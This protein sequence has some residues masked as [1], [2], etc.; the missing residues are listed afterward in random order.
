MWG[1][2][3]GGFEV[4][5]GSRGASPDCSQDEVILCSGTRRV[6]VSSS[7]TIQMNFATSFETPWGSGGKMKAG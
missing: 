2:G 5:E 1:G 4:L 6:L 7:Y 3:E